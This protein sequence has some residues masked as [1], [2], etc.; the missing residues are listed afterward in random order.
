MPV[1]GVRR[2]YQK[3]PLGL[4]LAL[5]VID[6]VHRYHQARGTKC[7]ELSWVFEDNR[8]VRRIIEMLGAKPYKTYRLYQKD[9]V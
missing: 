1:V 7:G 9:L 8:P 4:A 2:R 6:A 5:G 3:G